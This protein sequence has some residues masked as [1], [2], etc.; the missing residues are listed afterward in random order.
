MKL[1]NVVMVAASVVPAMV[2]GVLIEKARVQVAYSNEKKVAAFDRA[3]KYGW[4]FDAIYLLCQG[5][6]GDDFDLDKMAGA[7]DWMERY[8][9]PGSDC[10]ERMR[11]NAVNRYHLFSF[12][13]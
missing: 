5:Q 12:E 10:F 8:A 9:K 7:R 1:K 4:D 2:L 11:R 3:E 13:G 6:Y